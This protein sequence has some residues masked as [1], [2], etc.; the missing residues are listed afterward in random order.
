M[1]C[2]LALALT[3]DLALALALLN[4]LAVLCFAP[5]LTAPF[6][7]LIFL[8]LLCHLTSILLLSK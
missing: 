6:A 4:H 1:K 7:R 2:H 5:D 8:I 3:L